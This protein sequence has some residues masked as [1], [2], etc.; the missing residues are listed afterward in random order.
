MK[1]TFLLSVLILACSARQNAQMIGPCPSHADP[2]RKPQAI[3]TLKGVVIDENTGVV[4][5]V[6]VQLQVR[7]GQNFHDLE[8]VET[9]MTGGFT[10][11]KHAVG[12]YR[13]VFTGPA[14]FCPATIPVSYSNQG[15]NGLQLTLP[16]AASDTCPEYCESRLKIGEMTGRE[17]R[18]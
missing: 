5:K 4:P 12:Q 10:F 8:A 11:E 2:D 6:K 7:N 3:K 15:F 13:L 16:T 9:D 18:E 1:C 14:G 17:G